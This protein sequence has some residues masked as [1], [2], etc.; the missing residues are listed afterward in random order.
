MASFKPSTFK[1]NQTHGYTESS[2][3]ADGLGVL[4]NSFHRLHSGYGSTVHISVSMGWV[5]QER[6]RLSA[7]L[8]TLRDKQTDM[9]VS[10]FK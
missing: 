5:L 2:T 10:I 9:Y 6:L 8:I 3:E 7:L 4:L 1:P